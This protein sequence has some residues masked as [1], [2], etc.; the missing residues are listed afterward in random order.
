MLEKIERIKLS[1]EILYRL[2]EMIKNG[3]YSYG[4][5][6]PVEKR[7]AEIFGVSRTTVREALAVLEADGWVSTKRG[8]GTYVKRVKNAAPVEPLTS[9]LDSKNAAILESMEVRKI[10]ECEAAALAASRATPDD[11]VAIK[12]AYRDMAEAVQQGRETAEAD[13]NLH[14][15]IAH[16]A[17]NNTLC[18]VVSHLHELYREVVQTNR[19]H[20]AKPSSFELILAEHEAII[21]AIEKRQGR[22]ARKAM[23]LHLEQAHRLIEEVL[24][25]NYD[26]KTEN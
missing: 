12:A 25:E 18:S 17:R 20:K 26:A 3:Q 14:Y 13:Y 15:A 7:L 6:L 11:I 23:E 21:K 4:E 24:I 5:K 16:A 1:E 10:L 2:R 19:K 9:L 22:A 8:G